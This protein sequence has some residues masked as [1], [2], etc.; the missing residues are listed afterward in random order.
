MLTKDEIHYY[1]YDL[2]IFYEDLGLNEDG[3][4]HY[5]DVYTVQPSIYVQTIDDRALRFYLEAFKLTLEETR[6]LA[7]DFPEEDYGTDFFIALSEFY[8]LAQ[9]I[10]D[11]IKI[12]LNMLPDPVTSLEQGVPE[13]NWIN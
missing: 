8:K 7:P 3:I 13:I 10:P 1:D 5:S 2:N 11:R 4:E 6:A 9:V 12:L